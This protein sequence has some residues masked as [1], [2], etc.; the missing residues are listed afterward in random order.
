MAK[1]AA[2]EASIKALDQAI[3]THGGNGLT[4]RVRARDAARRG[5]RRPGRPGEPGDDPQLRRPALARPAEVV[6]M[7]GPMTS[8][9]GI[10]YGCEFATLTLDS[11]HNRNA[12]SGRLVDEL[13][14]GLARRGR[15]RRR[16]RRRA[17][18]HRRHVLRRRG[19]EREQDPACR[20]SAHPRDDRPAAEHR[21]SC[22]SRWSPGSTGTSGPAAWVCRG[23]RHRR[24]RAREHVRAHR[25]PDRLAPSIISLTLLPRIDPRAAS[26][27]FLTG[28]KFGA[29]TR[30]R[31]R[32]DHES[33]PRTPRHSGGAAGRSCG[34][35]SPQGL[36]ESR[37]LIDAAGPRRFDARHRRADRPVGAAV[38]FRGGGE[39]IARS[40]RSA[41]PRLGGDSSAWARTRG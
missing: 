16:A 6:L 2:A 8:S 33:R 5:A 3:Q 30:P 37:R 32:P 18:P 27:Y 11:P 34:K 14:R 23:L 4:T 22:P 1:Y 13:L 38:R 7:S 25:G 12:I 10:R 31:H 17:H 15:R 20:G 21:R 35:A 41:Q 9:D 39:G 24:R 26:R 28:E 40:C 36:A 19:S 29:A